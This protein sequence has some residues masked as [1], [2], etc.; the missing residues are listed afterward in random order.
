ME[1]KP[2]ALTAPVAATSVPSRVLMTLD[3][4]LVVVALKVGNTMPSMIAPMA[5]Q[6]RRCQASPKT[7]HASR[8]FFNTEPRIK[9]RP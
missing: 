1:S 5:S 7:C 3:W 6:V 2:V 9:N 8:H 4:R